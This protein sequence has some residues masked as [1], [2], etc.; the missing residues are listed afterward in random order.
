VSTSLI[1]LCLVYLSI[2]VSTKLF[3]LRISY[4]TLIEFALQFAFVK[5][6]TLQGINSADPLPLPSFQRTELASKLTAVGIDLMKLGMKENRKPVKTK[7]RALQ[8]ILQGIS[9]PVKV[10]AEVKLLVSILD[11]EYLQRSKLKERRYIGCSKKP[12]YLC[13]HVLQGLGDFPTRATHG[14][15]YS[16]WTILDTTM[17]TSSRSLSLHAIISRIGCEMLDILQKPREPMRDPVPES[18]LAITE[19]STR[20][21]FRKHRRRL[22]HDRHLYSP[23]P[24]A[25]LKGPRF[26][27]ARY[28]VRALVIPARGGEP[29]LVKVPIRPTLENYRAKDF[30]FK[31][32]PDFGVFWPEEQNFDRAFP[33]RW[34]V[35]NQESIRKDFTPLN[36]QYMI[37]YNDSEEL[38]PNKFLAEALLQG[39]IP[40]E[41]KFWNGDVIIVRLGTRVTS[42]STLH[43]MPHPIGFADEDEGTKET[44]KVEYD[45]KGATIFAD[46]SV[47]VIKFNRIWCSPVIE[48]PEIFLQSDLTLKIFRDFWENEQLERELE[49]DREI[50]QFQLQHETNKDLIFA[51]M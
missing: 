51:R 16:K 17:L 50:N 21:K 41:R 19:V 30:T 20:I 48:V 36:G 29:K 8:I 28:T 32:V 9:E 45:E 7:G 43:N 13:W 6:I 39:P 15:I 18:T 2:N 5:T 24:D 40:F 25:A 27:P 35:S 12:C 4:E 1:I 38:E 49:R 11:R 37:Y 34:D 46:V 47:S 10:H 31:E 33:I 3:L 22:D 23:E 14:K 42:R 26:G 44:P